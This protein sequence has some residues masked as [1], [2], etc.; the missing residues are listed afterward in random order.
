MKLIKKSLIKLG[1]IGSAIVVLGSAIFC[2]LYIQN[3]TRKIVLQRDKGNIYKCN[4]I[5][6]ILELQFFNYCPILRIK[7]HGDEKT[8]FYLTNKSKLIKPIVRNNYFTWNN[9]ESLEKNPSIIIICNDLD[10]NSFEAELLFH[11]SQGTSMIFL[12]YFFAFILFIIALKQFRS[13]RLEKTSK[14]SCQSL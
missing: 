10:K 9:L 4:Y 7:K 8:L 1:V 14:K 11:H 6:S 2:N 5:L 13:Y 12:L 3:T